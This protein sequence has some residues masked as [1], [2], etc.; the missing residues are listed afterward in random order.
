MGAIETD[1]AYATYTATLCK[2]RFLAPLDCSKI[3]AKTWS[4]RAGHVI[5]DHA[6]L[7]IVH[8]INDVEHAFVYLYRHH[9]RAGHI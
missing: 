1:Y 4:H 8:E 6:F 3:P 5:P 2:S 9:S 7:Q